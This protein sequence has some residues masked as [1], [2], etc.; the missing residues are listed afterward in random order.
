MPEKKLPKKP[1]RKTGVYTYIDSDTLNEVYELAYKK[2]FSM[3]STIL[4]LIK[5]GLE[6][7][8]IQKKADKNKK[9]N[10]EK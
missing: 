4:W 5:E 10:K 6:F 2:R 3:S 8:S 1:S 7:L 9:Q